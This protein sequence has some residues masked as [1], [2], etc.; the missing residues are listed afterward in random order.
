MHKDRKA[1][2]V[3]AIMWTIFLLPGF[4]C[5]SMQDG[6]RQNKSTKPERALQTHNSSK[7]LIKYAKGPTLPFFNWCTSFI[8]FPAWGLWFSCL[9]FWGRQFQQL[10]ASL[11]LI[12]KKSF[13]YVD[14]KILHDFARKSVLIVE[15]IM[16]LPQYTWQWLHLLCFLLSSQISIR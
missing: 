16:T 4:T 1:R 8:F 11:S 6:Y 15:V 13:V 14:S 2:N 5:L 12:V 3:P 10:F 9:F 7:I